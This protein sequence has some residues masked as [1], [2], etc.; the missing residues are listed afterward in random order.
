MKIIPTDAVDGFSLDSEYYSDDDTIDVE[1]NYNP[2]FGQEIMY[3]LIGE[4]N[5]V[6]RH[7][8]EHIKQNLSNYEFRDE[9]K[10]S[11]N[12]YSQEHELD[13][14]IA[15][16]KR[17]AKLEKRK[18]SDVMWD[19]FDKNSKRHNLNPD[20]VKIIIKKLLQRA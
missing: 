4:L 11:K 15:G 3:D 7:E 19:W 14:Q 10:K 8:L 2:K 17:R 1:I 20:E 16:F 9:P 6:I 13:A 18:L 5:D 12:Y